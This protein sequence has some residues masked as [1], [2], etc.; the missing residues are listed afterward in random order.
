MLSAPSQF[1]GAGRNFWLHLDPAAHHHR[2]EEA[3]FVQRFTG[4]ELTRF[5]V[6]CHVDDVKRPDMLPST[7]SFSGPPV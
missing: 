6:A 7:G 2:F 3:S 1:T 4:Y 5:V